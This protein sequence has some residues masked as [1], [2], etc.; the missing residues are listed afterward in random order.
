MK[1]VLSVAAVAL[2]LV[3]LMALVGC[4]SSHPKVSITNSGFSPAQ[5]STKAGG[6]VTWTNKDNVAHT[7]TGNDFDSGGLE[8]GKS[9]SHTFDAAGSYGYYSRF[10]PS[11]TGTVTVQ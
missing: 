2:A 11:L 3:A 9:Y 10:H 1:R 5:V 6:T 4:V 8:P 7:V